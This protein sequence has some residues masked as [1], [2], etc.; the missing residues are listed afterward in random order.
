MSERAVALA[1]DFTAFNDEVIAFVESC[2]EEDWQ[3]TTEAEGWTVAAVSRHIAAGHYAILGWAKMLVAGEELP[4]ITFDA[5]HG[6]NAEAAAASA[7][8]TQAEVLGL[9]RENGTAISEYVAS[10]SDDDLD[11]TASL[12]LIGGDISVEGFVN[13]FFI[14]SGGEHLASAK[15]TVAS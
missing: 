6:M 11:R 8:A 15:A 1:G 3:K 2:T 7:S 4:E 9:L 10:L 14:A 12:A 5:V 13:G